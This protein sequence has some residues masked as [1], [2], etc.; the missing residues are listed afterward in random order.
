MIVIWFIL[1]VALTVTNCWLV[2]STHR[3]IHDRGYRRAQ[4]F[5]TALLFIGFAAGVWFLTVR[6]MLSPTS[7]LH[8]VPVPIAS[9]DLIN[10]RWRDGGVSR[11]FWFAFVADITSG[12]AACVLPMRVWSFLRGR[13]ELRG[14]TNAA[15]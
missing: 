2:V 6:Y 3:I 13:R 9:G 1:V 5:F 7:R 11:I 4:R 14:V 12:I 10:G 8:G 15:S